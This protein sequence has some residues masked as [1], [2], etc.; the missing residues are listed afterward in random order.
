MFLEVRNFLIARCRG[1]RFKS[2]LLDKN[3]EIWV[4][5][6]LARKQIVRL[7]SDSWPEI[8]LRR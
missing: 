2:G 3:H 4:Q 1:R 5:I 7:P 8:G 6:P